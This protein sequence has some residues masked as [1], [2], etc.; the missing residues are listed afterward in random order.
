MF[1]MSK[2]D[3]FVAK[4]FKPAFTTN[5]M[6]QKGQFHQTSNS[7]EFHPY[8]CLNLMKFVGRKKQFLL[9]PCRSGISKYQLMLIMH[10][11]A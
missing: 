3:F 7:G 10:A 1:A 9:K 11:C 6:V 4:T 5:T 8:K 2:S